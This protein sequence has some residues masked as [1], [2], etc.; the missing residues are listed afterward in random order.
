MKSWHQPHPQIR[1][2]SLVLYG[3]NYNEPRKRRSISESFAEHPI[4][5]NQFDDEI[6]QLK[7]TIRTRDD[8]ILNLKREIHKLKVCMPK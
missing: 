2:T 7:D 5:Q 4:Y 8:E 1:K 6:Q 3:A